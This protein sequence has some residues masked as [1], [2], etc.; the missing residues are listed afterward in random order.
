MLCLICAIL[1][2]REPLTMHLISWIRLH[3]PTQRLGLQ[4][5]EAFTICRK[6]KA[7]HGRGQFLARSICISKGEICLCGQPDSVSQYKWYAVGG[8]CP[9]GLT[10]PFF[11]FLTS[12]RRLLDNLRRA[13][14]GPGSLGGLRTQAQWSRVTTFVSRKFP[15][16]QGLKP[17]RT[18]WSN[19]GT[20]PSP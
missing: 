19:D 7:L 9:G 16:S 3:F 13:G 1:F 18:A 20:A 5:A 15:L 6:A 14:K 11:S 12:M 2:L 8:P 17:E 10:D 4:A